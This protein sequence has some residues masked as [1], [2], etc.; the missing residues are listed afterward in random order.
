[1]TPRWSPWRIVTFFGLVSMAGDLVYEG[2]RSI[3]GP[4]LESLGASALLVGIV[5]G[6]GEGAALVLR[7]VLREDEVCSVKGV[8]ALDADLDLGGTAESLCDRRAAARPGA[9]VA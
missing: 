9:C 1:M 3:T 2:A 4:Y 8:G 7:L 6:V 5:T